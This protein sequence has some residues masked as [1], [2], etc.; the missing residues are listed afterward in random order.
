MTV[1]VQEKA[2]LCRYTA[3]VRDRVVYRNING[4]WVA[5]VECPAYAYADNRG[6]AKVYRWRWLARL[7]ADWWL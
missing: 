3:G 7:A 4:D 5:A 2:Y 1:W 6:R